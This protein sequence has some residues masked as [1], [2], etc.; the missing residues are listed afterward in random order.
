VEYLLG[1]QMKV[2]LALVLVFSNAGNCSAGQGA[3]N[4]IGHFSNIV[5][6]ADEDPHI[7]SGFGVKLYQKDKTLFGN[8]EIGIGSAEAASGRLYDIEFDPLTNQLNFKAKYS[9]GW[10]ISRQIGPEGRASHVLMIF[11]GKMTNKSLAG[12]IVLKDGC[13]L[14]A[15]GT[16]THAVMKRIKDRYV[17]TNLDEWAAYISPKP[18]GSQWRPALSSR[19]R[20]G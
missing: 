11:S 4:L 8:V 6:T 9:S 14:N 19:T 12:T 15:P 5:A 10:E 13:N 1:I 16:K 3:I 7:V 17:P 18:S 20:N 2:I